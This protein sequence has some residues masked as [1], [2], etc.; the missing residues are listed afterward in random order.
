[1]ARTNK[2][3]SARKPVFTHEGAKAVGTLTAV[4]QLRRSVMSCMLFEGE[5]YEDGKSIAD[6]IL[7]L[8]KKVKPEELAQIAI[9]ARTEHNLRHVPL[10]LLTALVKTGKG[11][12]DGLVANTI[13]QTLRRADELGE[14]L[15]V[16]KKMN[17]GKRVPLAKQLQK[18]LAQAFV[19]FDEYQ[20]GKYNKAKGEVDYTLKDVLFLSHAEPVNREQA[21]LWKRLVKDKIK[22]PDT[23]E[24]ALSGGADKGE[25]FTRLIEE[26]KLGY[27]A[28]L[29]NLRNMAEAGVNTSLVNK[30]IKARKNGAD[31]I[32]PFRFTAAARAAPQFERAIDD[33]LC[34]NIEAMPALPGK[35]LVLVDV[36][37]SMDS[38]L[39]GKS[40]LSRADAAA[41]LAAVINAEELVVFSFS[42][43]LVQTKGRRGMA[44][45]EEILKSQQHGGTALGEA[46]RKAKELHPDFDRI[47]VLSDEQSQDIVRSPVTV[48]GDQ[49]A[50]M[51]NV[52]SSQNGVGYRNGWTHIDGFSESVLKY[53]AMVEG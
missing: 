52:A 22:T 7:T 14:L 36:S 48:R 49:R 2:T 43:R 34:A 40:D 44:G 37:G 9:E 3:K 8:A 27:F 50:Y 45:V 41:T 32:L 11:R 47:I 6:R 29:R 21:R 15:A 31:R 16:Y 53:I 39:S 28:L 24:V 46:V 35:T 38:K 25:A 12:Q 1:M 26:D 19:K 10:V 23:W 5:F 17:G 51:I 18:G 13:A 42:N 4:E 20:L 30:A 33:A